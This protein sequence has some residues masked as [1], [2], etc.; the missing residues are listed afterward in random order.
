MSTNLALEDM[1]LTL[2]DLARNYGHLCGVAI[3][4]VPDNENLPE[5]ILAL[6]DLIGRQENQRLIAEDDHDHSLCIQKDYPNPRYRV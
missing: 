3:Q 2:R 1:I 4:M 6:W 5:D